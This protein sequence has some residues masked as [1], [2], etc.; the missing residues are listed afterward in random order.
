MNDISDQTEE[1]VDFNDNFKPKL[2]IETVSSESVIENVNASQNLN[3]NE[4]ENAS[5]N[6]NPQ[7][8]PRISS[9]AEQD[10]SHRR[11][12]FKE[13]SAGVLIRLADRTVLADKYKKTEVQNENTEEK[14]SFLE[15]LEKLN[16]Q[17][18]LRRNSS[19]VLVEENITKELEKYRQASSYSSSTEISYQDLAQDSQSTS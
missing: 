3:A 19:Q 15:M 4:N 18:P 16:A 9:A 17:T 5:E 14:D 10:V 8:Q 1:S 2:D 7:K 12:S 6:V 11:I 13:E